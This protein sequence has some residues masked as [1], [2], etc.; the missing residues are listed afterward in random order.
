MSN[1][2][3]YSQRLLTG[4]LV[5]FAEASTSPEI[6]ATSKPAADN[7]AWKEIGCVQNLVHQEQAHEEEYDCPHPVRGWRSKKD[8]WVFG[9]R[10]MLTTRE[11]SELVHRLALGVASPLALDGAQEPNAVADRRV[12]GWIK[13]QKRMPGGKDRIIM[14]LWCD[15]RLAEEPGD[16][17][18]VQVPVLELEDLDSTLKSVVM[19]DPA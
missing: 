17:K 18:A 19:P 11:T 16:A 2:L 12:R 1:K 10:Y 7:V 3:L 15:V 8:R 4:A 6:S 9:D 13:I 14:D 5:F